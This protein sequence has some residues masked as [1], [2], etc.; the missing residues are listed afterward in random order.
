MTILSGEPVEFA[1]NVAALVLRNPWPAVADLD[2]DR[3]SAMTATDD[4]AARGRVAD[5]IR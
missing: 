2:A 5:R 1:E 4:Y 3:I